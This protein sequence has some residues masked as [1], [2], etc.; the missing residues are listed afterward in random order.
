MPCT[1]VIGVV[2]TTRR[3][4]LIE[5]PVPQIYRPLRQLPPSVTSSSVSFFG[6]T[7]VVGT[8][9]DPEALVETVRRTMQSTN[10]NVPFANVMT[11][12]ALL[13]RHTRAWELGARVFTAFGALALAL[14]AVGLFSVVAFTIGQRMHEF[15]IR[16]ALGARPSDLLVLTLVRGV[17]PAVLGIVAG[18]ILALGAGRFVSSLL[19]NVTPN[20]PLVLGGASGALFAC[21]V[22]ASIVPAMRAARVDPTIALRAE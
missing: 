12:R 11:M 17:A 13:G 10:Q 8:R 21:A 6:Y 20:D 15:G 14:A 3:Q 2:N 4:D 9:G 7:L 19:F 1:T 16:T 18:V 22:V 5:T